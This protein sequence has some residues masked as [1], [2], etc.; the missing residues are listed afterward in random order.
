MPSSLDPQALGALIAVTVMLALL[1]VLGVAALLA[2][3]A[4][5]RK[6]DRGEL[7]WT[8]T[9]AELRIDSPPQILTAKQG[10]TS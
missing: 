7:R 5:L 1:V 4:W 6:H 8:P 10:E 3:W 9:G 2:V